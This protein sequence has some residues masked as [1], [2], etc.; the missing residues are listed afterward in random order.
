MKSWVEAADGGG[1]RG[2]PW[3]NWLEINQNPGEKKPL[4]ARWRGPPESSFHFLH[5]GHLCV[6]WLPLTR[7]CL[8]LSNSLRILGF[9]AAFK[10]AFAG[11]WILLAPA[12]AFLV[13]SGEK[14]LPPG[15]YTCNKLYLLHP[16][17]RIVWVLAAIWHCW[18]T[19]C[20][21]SP[22]VPR[23]SPAALPSHS[24][25]RVVCIN[26]SYWKIVPICQHWISFGWFWPCSTICQVCLEI[27][28]LLLEVLTS[29][30][31]QCHEI[32]QVSSENT[33]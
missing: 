32:I 22:A 12:E 23:L 16:Q 17:M 11:N 15:V 30:P 24:N 21:W 28:T 20:S 31:E 25:F 27:L 2:E 1:Q 19:V 18:F 5:W 14:W 29:P 10:D 13:L 9:F 6:P 7:V 26:S 33:E 3:V 8:N 4:S